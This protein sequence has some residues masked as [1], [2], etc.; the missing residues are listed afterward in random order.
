MNHVSEDMKNHAYERMQKDAR[1][2]SA[3]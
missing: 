3:R 1:K 2:Y